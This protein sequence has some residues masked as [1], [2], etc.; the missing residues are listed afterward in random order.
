MKDDAVQRRYF[1]TDG[2]RGRV[3]EPPMTVEFA[4]ALGRVLGVELGA[5]ATVT[6][7]RDT[8]N[9]GPMLESALA[10]GLSESGVH[11]LSL[12]VVP[13]PAVAFLTRAVGA[14]AGAV[15]SASHNLFEDNG[16]KFFGADGEKLDD[17]TEQHLESRLNA[18]PPPAVAPGAMGS[19]T[20]LADAGERYLAH[21]RAAVPELDLSD[22]VLV[23]DC[24]NGAAAGLAPDLFAGLGAT[25]IPIGDAPDGVNINADC[26]STHMANTVAAVRD[27][28]ADL[29]IAFD[30]DADRVQMVDAHG[31]VL[32]GDDLLL[33][34]ASDR[35]EQ[36]RLEGG[37][38][39]T[40]MTNL[41]LAQAFETMGVPFQRAKVGDRYVLEL[42]KATGG[43]LGGE[44]SGHLLCLDES[45]TGDG[46]LSAIL[47]LDAVKRSGRSLAEWRASWTRH[48]QVLINVRLPERV[49]PWTLPGVEGAVREV[50]A[51]L[52]DDGRVVLRAS[53]TEPLVRVM[54]EGADAGRV[55]AEAEGLADAVRSGAAGA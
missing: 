5:G 32:D 49:D 29:G 17:T 10:A 55:R 11:V 15:I 41:G 44:A 3:G 6:V 16:I 46:L 8:R 37:V 19:I 43:R 21:I 51:R 31:E 34:L 25:V 38:V 4:V 14:R 54:V 42:L 27:R 23:V 35:R 40:L 48:P 13:T 50:E 39:G 28:G 36:G 22:T 53:G 30:G 33:I 47:V 52:G 45:T 24:A 26:G 9:S 12:G 7:G 2:V 1:G 20:G 18:D